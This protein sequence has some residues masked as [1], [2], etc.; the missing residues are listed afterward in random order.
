M[1]GSEA[2]IAQLVAEGVEVVLSIPGVHN[3]PLCDVIID[4]PE[5]RFI[6]GRHEQAI[7]FMANGYARASGK[8][9]VPLVITGPGVANSITPLA[10][11]YQD[12]VPMVLVASQVDTQRLG[13]GAFHELKDQTG[14][15]ASVTKWN[16]RVDR[17]EEIPEAIRAAFVQAYE[18]RPGP[19][20]IEI[21]LDVQTQRGRADIYPSSRP[22][23]RRADPAAV[24]EAA[25]RLAEAT[26]PLVYVGSGAVLSGCTAEVIRLIEHLNAPCRVTVLAK[27]VV[28]D[29]HPLNLGWWRDQD[30]LAH[31]FL[32]EADAILVI[33]SSL[34]EADTGGGTLPLPENLIQI[35]TCAEMIGRNYPVAVGLEGDAK[36][37]LAQLL[38]AL[39]DCEHR[40]RP[41]PAPRIAEA[42]RKAQARVQEELPWRWMNAVQQ[43]LPEDAVVTN[44]AS[45]SSG[46][47]I[48]FL[49]RDLP[50]TFNITRSMAALGYAF[51]AAVG[52]KL[53][54][55]D[56]QAVAV[57]G[58]GGFLFTGYA[59]STAVKYHINA[60]AIVFDN[61][62]YGTIR[63]IQMQRFG[64]TIGADLHNP[65]FVRLAE[66][67]GAVGVRVAHPDQLY[68]ALMA[69]WERDVPSLIEVPIPR[70]V[71]KT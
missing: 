24:R 17:M 28:P 15:L 18:G 70:S 57:V 56:R 38:E 8:I 1:T 10:D 14:L 27:G 62:G 45:G 4:R 68:E 61:G 19:T 52:A 11:A 54:Y 7:T 71:A 9:A 60:V 13:K 53:A 42:K 41:S 25:C 33:G 37:V 5:L 48:S 65:D 39:A 36:A 34:D 49:Q 32:K 3:L 66:A 55:P 22:E 35:D 50:R 26:S 59:L 43:A 44:D 63:R 20:A 30:G 12:S 16:T 29:D 64:R 47:A 2:A 69:A 58:D 23:R 46:W 6:S 31:R 40:T 51:P 21:P 67:Y